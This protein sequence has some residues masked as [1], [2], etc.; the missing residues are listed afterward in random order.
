MR[1]LFRFDVDQIAKVI[2]D[3]ALAI[4]IER[5]RKPKCATIGQRAKASID[6]IESRIDQL[7]RDDEAAQE[8]GDGAMR[9][10]VGAKFVTAKENVATEESVAFAFEIQILRQPHD[11]VA[12]LF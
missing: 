4:F 2:A 11:V 9:I 8:I 6:M 3:G 7:D 5:V 1:R 10:D 12:V